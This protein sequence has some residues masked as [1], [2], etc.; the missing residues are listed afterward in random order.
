MSLQTH[1]SLMKPQDASSVFR[2]RSIS[3][4]HTHIHINSP[5]SFPI[6]ISL[7]VISLA[8]ISLAVIS[9]AVISL[10]DFMNKNISTPTIKTSQ[11][12]TNF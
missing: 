2:S 7:A 9:L 11:G 8:V 3:F 4:S 6:V 5:P 10:A 1:Q 12:F